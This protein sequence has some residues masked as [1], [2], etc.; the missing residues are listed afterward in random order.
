MKRTLP[1]LLSIPLLAGGCSTELEVNAPYEGHTVV[2]G[3]LN[4][5]DSVQ[6][7]KINKSFLGDGSAL[8]YAQ[9]PD[10]NEYGGEAISRLYV[11]KVINGQRVETYTV[12]D[13]IVD[14]REPGTFHHPVQK[15]YYFIDP[16]EYII[17]VGAAS[18]RVYLDQAAS[19][20]LD[21]E[22]NGEQISGITPVVNDFFFS[23]TLNSPNVAVSLMHPQN[24]YGSFPVR[25]DSG[26][27]GKRYVVQ[28]RFNYLE[29][30]E[31]DTLA[32]SIVQGLGT[33]VSANAQQNEEMELFMDGQMFY[34]NLASVI[35]D[36][37]EVIKRIFTG[38]DFLFTVANDD[39]HTFLSL[40]EPVSGIVEE[41]P[42]Y[43]NVQGG[44][45]VFASRYNKEVIGKRLAPTAVIELIDGPITAHLRFCSAFPQDAAFAGCN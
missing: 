25:W 21:L 1:F 8:G 38:I 15:L 30:T 28:Y 9:I 31:N 14:E 16:E 23:G 19:Y 45:G 22:V 35:V 40:S 12:H 36:R 13:T 10:S 2:Y 17:G 7:I 6:F 3:L 41:R 39:F 11:H 32:Q 20:E 26:P 33:R 5:R 37:P 29:V 4:Q 24:G 34:S 44:Y 27:D 43:S 42:A 18:F